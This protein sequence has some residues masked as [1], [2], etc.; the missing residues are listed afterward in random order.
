MAPPS[1]EK[2]QGILPS[3]CDFVGGVAA[4]LGAGGAY[5]MASL[6]GCAALA[7]EFGLECGVAA[8][9]FPPFE[10]VCVYGDSVVA[11]AC[12]AAVGAGVAFGA[13]ELMEAVGCDGAEVG[14]YEA[15]QA[16]PKGGDVACAGG[17][18]SND[19]YNATDYCCPG[20]VPG[21]PPATYRGWDMMRW[22]K[23]KCT[24]PDDPGSEEPFACEGDPATAKSVCVVNTN[25]AQADRKF[26][27]AEICEA[28]GVSECAGVRRR[29]Q[30]AH[31]VAC[32]E[33]GSVATHWGNLT[34]VNGCP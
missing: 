25:L 30:D 18:C 3:F 23:Y 1:K 4:V 15:G 29:N 31:E 34:C 27:P 11:T 28:A 26:C 32:C 7:T 6:G 19:D 8:I 20:P 13:K 22:C 16:C 2:V 33:V 9:A 10:A 5:A 17:V 14:V 21:A 24:N 12:V